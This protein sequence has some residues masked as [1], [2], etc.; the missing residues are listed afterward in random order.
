MKPIRFLFCSSLVLILSSVAATAQSIQTDYDHSFNLARLKTFEFQQQIRKPND[1]LAGSP[2][3]DRRI[4]NALDTQLKAN[5]FSA[6]STGNPDFLIAYFVSTRK[7]LDIRD[8]RFGVLQRMGSVN[9]NQVT[10][11]SIVV[12]FIDRNTQQEVWRGFVSGTVDPKDL[13]KDINKGIAKLV[14]KFV[15]D[16]LGK[17]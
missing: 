16:Q 11:G 4:H 3:N 9:V 2:M 1:A 14:Q 12:V 17:R 10:E 5:G 13:D 15:K 8:N 6:G 7:G